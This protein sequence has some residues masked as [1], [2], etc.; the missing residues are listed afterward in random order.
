MPEDMIL[1]EDQN[2]DDTNDEFEDDVSGDDEL[3]EALKS[4]SDSDEDEDDS[5][6]EDDEDSDEDYEDEDEDEYE[7]ED[8]DIDEDED[9]DEEYEETDEDKGAKREQ[10]REE[11]ARFA[12]QRRQQ[13]LDAKVQAELERLKQESPEFQLAKQLSEMY[14]RPAQEIMSEMKEAALQKEAETSKVPLKMLKER[15]V[16]RERLAQVEAELNQL[17]YERWENRIKTEASTLQNDFKM[18]S[19]EDIDSAVNYI[20]NEARNVDMP[21]EQA[22][23]ALHGKKIIENMVKDKAQDKLANDSG[24]KKKVPLSPNNGKPFQSKSIT[25]EERYV[26]E[27][28]GMSVDDYLK[29]K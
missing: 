8:E 11:N 2:I 10:S 24:R 20:L 6:Y 21:L 26:A 28:M 1:P 9:F 7:Y 4:L 27:Q 15:E 22:V 12:A 23:Y 3:F 17:R 19:H 25:A 13:E 14:G 29:Y 16:E 18:L 5:E